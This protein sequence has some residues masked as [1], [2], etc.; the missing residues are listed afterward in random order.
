MAHS[1]REDLRVQARSCPCPLRA[2]GPSA[3]AWGWRWHGDTGTL[4]LCWEQLLTLGKGRESK[5]IMLAYRNSLSS[6]PR[7]KAIAAPAP[8]GGRGGDSTVGQVDARDASP[9]T[10][11]LAALLATRALP[12]A[13][14]VVPR[15]DH[16][17]GD[18]DLRAG[19]GSA[20]RSTGRFAAAERPRGGLQGDIFPLMMQVM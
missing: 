1:S 15:V 17:A 8:R 10:E 12:V 16:G 2:G 6:L 3:G 9:P 7:A 5:E 20:C 11:G 13:V 19:P 4:W 14:A 18:A